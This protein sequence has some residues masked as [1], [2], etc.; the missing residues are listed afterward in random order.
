[1]NM[2]ELKLVKIVVIP[3]QL[4]LVKV[5]DD[6]YLLWKQHVEAAVIGYDLEPYLYGIVKIPRQF[7]VSDDGTYAITNPEFH[8]Y[9]RQDKLLVSWLLNSLSEGVQQM[10]VRKETTHEIWRV[11]KGKFLFSNYCKEDAIQI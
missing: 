6:N 3:Q 5:G 1:M 9:R 11:L 8:S 7:M 4:T 10:V 2:A